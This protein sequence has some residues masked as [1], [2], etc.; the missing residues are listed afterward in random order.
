[1]E[2]KLNNEEISVLKV[3]LKQLTIRS[4]TGELGIIHG[5]NRFVSTNQT[6]KKNELEHLDEIAKKIGLANGLGRT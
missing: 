1:M 6:F 2:A 3:V 4:R 5:M